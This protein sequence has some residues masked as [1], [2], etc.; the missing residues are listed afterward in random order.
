MRGQARHIVRFEQSTVVASMV[1]TGL[2]GCR[3]E[4]WTQ[5]GC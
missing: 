2:R 1:A 5:D 3:I 4:E